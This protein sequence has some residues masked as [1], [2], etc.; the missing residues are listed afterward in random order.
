MAE[1]AFAGVALEFFETDVEVEAEFA[2][3]EHF[4]IVVAGG[5]R[6]VVPRVALVFSDLDGGDG[7]EFGCLFV[8]SQTFSC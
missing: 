3:V 7:F 8:G 5:E 1:G 2:E 4:D 6:G